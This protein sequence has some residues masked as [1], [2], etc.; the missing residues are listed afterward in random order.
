MWREDHAGYV[1]KEQMDVM[2]IKVLSFVLYTRKSDLLSWAADPPFTLHSHPAPVHYLKLCKQFRPQEPTPASWIYVITL[3][4][5]LST[6]LLI[7]R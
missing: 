1:R 5:L 3:S 4:V 2:L 7:S 6:G